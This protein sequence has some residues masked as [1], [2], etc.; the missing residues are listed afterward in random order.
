ME[1]EIAERLGKF[2]LS[3]REEEIMEISFDDTKI[4]RE[5]YKKSL[6]GWIFGRNAINFT[7]LKQTMSKLWCA[8]GEL[9][10]IELKSKLYKFVFSSEEERMRVLEKHP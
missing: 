4:S 9:N 5:R 6:V 3:K 1:S 8:E 7:G 10:V 2:R